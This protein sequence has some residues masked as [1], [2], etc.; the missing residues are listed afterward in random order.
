MSNHLPLFAGLFSF[1][2]TTLAP[3]F[4]FQFL[5]VPLCSHAKPVGFPRAVYCVLSVAFRF[6]QKS[7]FT[8]TEVELALAII[9]SLGSSLGSLGCQ[10]VRLSVFSRYAKFPCFPQS[11]GATEL[12]QKPEQRVIRSRM[13]SWA[14]HG[15][16]SEARS[17]L[18][19]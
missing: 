3:I 6:R 14:V 5:L 19:P 8:Y 13:F 1:L 10:P 16:D 11:M 17:A 18:P 9:I 15:S 7:S 2:S 12:A 4:H